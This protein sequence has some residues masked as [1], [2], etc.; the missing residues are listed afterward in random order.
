[1]CVTLTTFT[2][3]LLFSY[4]TRIEGTEEMVEDDKNINLEHF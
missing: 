1:M 4:K 2:M 3:A